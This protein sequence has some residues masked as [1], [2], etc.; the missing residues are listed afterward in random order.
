MPK[1][2]A[3]GW[4]WEKLPLCVF[5]FLHAQSL[6]SLR[7][8]PG[9]VHPCG[10]RP[11]G[12]QRPE[13]PFHVA[14]G[15]RGRSCLKPSVHVAGRHGRTERVSPGVAG[16]SLPAS[17]AEKGGEVLNIHVSCACSGPTRP[18]RHRQAPAQVTLTSA[19][20]PHTWPS[21]ASFPLP[22]PPGDSGIS[23]KGDEGS[24]PCG[25]TDSLNM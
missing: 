13:L 17:A 22:Q 15:V 6:L 12:G 5:T 21:P 7:P 16:A 11:E 10:Q 18:G 9:D 24:P 14:A 20:H 4:G 2:R 25:S 3:E 19:G 23:N 8:V 1:T